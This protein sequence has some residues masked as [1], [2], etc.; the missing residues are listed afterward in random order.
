VGGL[1]IAALCAH[2]SYP[3]DARDRVM[4]RG[5][6]LPMAP[7]ARVAESA[8]SDPIT[9]T[10]GLALRNQAE[11]RRLIRRLNDPDSA[12]YRQFL[13]AAEFD[14]RFGAAASDAAAVAAYLGAH[15]LA[16]VD[17]SPSRQ[18]I[19]AVGDRA[20]IERAFAVT[21]RSY[22][23]NGETFFAPDR[24]PS[25][26]AA[27]A[28]AVT[29]VQGLENRTQLRALNT[30][31]RV[32]PQDRTPFTPAQI[33]A[34]YNFIPLYE[35]GLRGDESR[36]ATIAVATAFGF[37]PSDA[38]GFWQTLGV[39][40]DMR[41]VE[42]IPIGGVATRNIDETTL[43]VEWAGAMAPASRLL[44]YVAANAGVGTFTAMYD[45]IVSDNR[46][47]VISTS[48]GLCETAMPRA[49]LDQT[50][51]IFQKAAALGISVLAA[52]GDNGAFDCRA[53]VLGVNYPAADSFATAVG[54]TSLL[55]DDAAR[56][57]SERAWRGSGGGA[58]SLFQRPDWQM[59]SSPWRQSADVALNADPATGYFVRNEG[60]WWSYGGT[61][62]AAPIWAALTALTN[63]LRAQ[64]GQ[65]PI[66]GVA[67]AVC[68]LALE[69]PNAASPFVDVIEGDNGGY[70][71][72]RG[73]DY[74]T[75]WGVPDAWAVARSLTE[76]ARPFSFSGGTSLMTYL[77]PTAPD[78]AGTVR[79]MVTARC[80]RART[81]IAA[82]RL[83]PGLYRV[84]LDETPEAEFAVGAR[85]TTRVTLDGIDP[86]GHRVALIDLHGRV[87]FRADFPTVSTRPIHLRATLSNPGRV[88][89]ARGSIAYHRADGA[90]QYTVRVSGL[91]VGSYQLFA[92]SQSVATVAVRANASGR[93]S[94]TLRF[95]SRNVSGT[96]CP[97][98]LRCQRL[99]V[100]NQS[101]VVLEL[102]ETAPGT[103]LCP[104]A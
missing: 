104:S 70:P 31:P 15:G 52:S 51:A 89:G 24:D 100:R 36:A 62:V 75:G 103:G 29:S 95:D 4:L 8:G 42:V 35:R 63:Q 17:V 97:A 102:L 78:V 90:E 82:R 19:T 10:V 68:D 66:G 65:A 22:D 87:L 79:M 73:W 37:N 47:A 43:D 54:G 86:R 96:K 13:T 6:R 3:A 33:A 5:H 64:Q 11:L 91:P 9:V 41:R 38:T 32:P 84:A 61:S 85:G 74:P 101:T 27:L 23:A 60:A 48:W 98:D 2:T 56:R 59:S 7:R 69:E 50:H 55:I 44:V 83:P 81:S 76:S 93:T 57:V 72:G 34:A 12:D 30:G 94:G 53:N 99:R 14:E 80:T 45:R 77:E 39:D 88:R 26:P 1:L 28:P 67:P 20:A 71:A 25:L 58:S 16:V 40:R 46:A 18:L 49:D 92:A 21:L